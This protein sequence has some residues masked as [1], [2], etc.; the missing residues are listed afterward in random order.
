M[1]DTEPTHARRR[2]RRSRCS[3]TFRYPDYE[4]RCLGKRLRRVRNVGFVDPPG[5]D[6]NTNQNIRHMNLSFVD[7]RTLRRLQKPF[8]CARCQ[9][10][11]A[12]VKFLKTIED[13][14][15]LFRGSHAMVYRR[16]VRWTPRGSV[17]VK[18]ERT[19]SRVRKKFRNKGNGGRLIIRLSGS[20]HPPSPLVWPI[21]KKDLEQWTLLVRITSASAT[22]GDRLRK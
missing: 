16:E 22:I 11:W 18:R 21:A 1:S 4:G 19:V 17:K 15:S 12:E 9:G 5:L 20:P 2:M 10:I 8:G 13:Q 3:F 6:L 14:F 7:S